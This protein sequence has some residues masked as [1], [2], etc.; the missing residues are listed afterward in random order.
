MT[1]VPKSQVAKFLEGICVKWASTG[2]LLVWGR[3]ILV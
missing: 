3:K 1:A 2:Q